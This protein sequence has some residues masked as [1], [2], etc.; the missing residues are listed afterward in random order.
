MALAGP[1]ASRIETS[2][3]DIYYMLKYYYWLFGQRWSYT[4]AL[5][6]ILNKKDAKNLGQFLGCQV[7][8]IF[9]IVII[10]QIGADQVWHAY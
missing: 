4:T 8:L 3:H 2:L 9:F 10:F 7:F 1:S 5:W 6:T